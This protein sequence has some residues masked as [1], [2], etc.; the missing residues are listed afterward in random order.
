MAKLE[1]G[2]Y[3][4]PFGRTATAYRGARQ[5]E[6]RLFWGLA[7]HIPAR[8]AAGRCRMLYPTPDENLRLL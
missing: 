1:L 6:A 5:G 7:V 3:V 4:R 8:C 2:S